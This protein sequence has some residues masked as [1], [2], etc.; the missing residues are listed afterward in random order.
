[1]NRFAR[2]TNEFARKMENHATAEAIRKS[3]GKPRLIGT[4]V[5][6]ILVI[7]LALWI[8]YH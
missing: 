1:M 2:L 3:T 6:I 5:G 4:V 7:L 8:A